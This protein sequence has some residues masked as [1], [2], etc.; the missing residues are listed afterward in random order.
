MGTGVASH[1]RDHTGETMSKDN[2]RPLLLSVEDACNM[3]RL[4][5]TKLYQEIK[6]GRLE[7]IRVGRLRRIPFSAL[8]NW[9]AARVTK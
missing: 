1:V 2:E 4:G 6:S 8:E 9:I 7:S 3:L 5:R